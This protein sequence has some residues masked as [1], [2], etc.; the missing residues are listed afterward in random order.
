[1]IH[2]YIV[3]GS[4]NKSMKT[5]VCFSLLSSQQT[6]RRKSK[7]MYRGKYQQ[8]GGGDGGHGIIDIRK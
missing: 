3:F 1:M 7:T 4:V 8:R 6:Y 2:I 5:S